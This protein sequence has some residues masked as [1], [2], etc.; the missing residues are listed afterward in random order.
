MSLNA[1][2]GLVHFF[3]LLMFQAHSLGQGTT[4]EYSDAA[5]L[6]QAQKKE[7]SFQFGVTF[8]VMYVEVGLRGGHEKKEMTKMTQYNSEV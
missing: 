8:G 7:S 3:Y 5:S 1:K 4:E 2:V 6:L